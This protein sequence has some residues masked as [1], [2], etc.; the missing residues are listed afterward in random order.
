[1]GFTKENAKE[2]GHKGGIKNGRKPK[3]AQWL[4]LSEAIIGE[5]ADKFNKEINKLEGAEFIKAYTN[6]LRYF[7]PSLQSTTFDAG[8][9]NVEFEIRIK[10]T[11]S[12]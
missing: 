2:L 8:E 3:S 11:E 5:H 1:M 4:A 6:V 9:G 10:T 7:R 12:E